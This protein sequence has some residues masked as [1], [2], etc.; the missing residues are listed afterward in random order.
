MLLLLAQTGPTADP[1]EW[2]Q[3]A[4]DRG[5]Q[6]VLILGCFIFMTMLIR[7]HKEKNQLHKDRAKLEEDYRKAQTAQAEG[8]RRHVE[9]LEADFRSKI[10]QLLREQVKIAK[11]TT[12]VL[13]RATQVLDSLDIITGEPEDPTRRRTS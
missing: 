9:E 2:M 4:L 7:L 5:V 13:T 12:L 6:G 1:R 3:W 10:E 11:E 8:F